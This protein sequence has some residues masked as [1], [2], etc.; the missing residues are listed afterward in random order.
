VSQRAGD[1][2]I[3]DMKLVLLGTGNPNPDPSRSGPSSAII[4]NGTSYIIDAGPG[5]VRRAEEAY[6][7]GIEELKVN[8]LNRLFL[9]HLHSDHTIGI[10]D[11]IL[12]PWVMERK[13]PL[14]IW[15]P[16]GTDKMCR[17]LIKAY[18][19]DIQVRMNGLENANSNGIQLRITEIGPG[20]VFE[21][22]G[23]KVTA[24]QTRHGAWKHSLGFRFEAEDRTIAISG[25]CAIYPG[26]EE[27]YK[28]ADILLN[29]AYSSRGFIDLPD[30]WKRYHESSHTS[31]KDLG[32]IANKVSP[33]LLIV[34]HA[35]LWNSSKTDLLK[36]IR[37]YYD[38]EVLIGE[39]LDLF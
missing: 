19:E 1:D 8:K 7:R 26:M 24:F 35:L 20:P 15:G 9:T 38:G 32:I 25:D 18:D 34:N 5:I 39:D 36:E 11:I 13:E 2:L 14:S 16:E 23:L 12:T 22:D 31:G 21:E 3:S 29:E 33:G 4:H 28:G 6:I 17:S 27:N 30:K 10:P 37:S